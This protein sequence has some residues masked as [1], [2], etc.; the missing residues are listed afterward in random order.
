MRWTS[1]W[2]AISPACSGSKRE[3]PALGID[4]AREQIADDAG[5]VGIL[6]NH[7][8][9]LAVANLELE[10]GQW[11]VSDPPQLDGGARRVDGTARVD[12]RHA[13]E[14][15]RDAARR[16]QPRRPDVTDLGK[17]R[18]RYGEEHRETGE[19]HERAR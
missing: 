13:L 10:V 14:D 1:S 9:Q 6:G 17:G 3:R 15:R 4:T 8:E 16:R 5:D 18:E 7:A 2:A 11:P 19:R 12:G